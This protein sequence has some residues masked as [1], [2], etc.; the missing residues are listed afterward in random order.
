MDARRANDVAKLK[1]AAQPTAVDKAVARVFGD[2]SDPEV[3]AALKEKMG[4]VAR[5]SAV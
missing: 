1:D 3:A 4:Q 5:G 2:V